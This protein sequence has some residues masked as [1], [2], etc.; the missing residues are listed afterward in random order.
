MV[1]VNSQLSVMTSARAY[2]DADVAVM[3]SAMTLTGD[4][5]TRGVHE[6]RG[7][8]FTESLDGA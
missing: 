3:T 8:I 5:A 7:S 4:P 1:K 2:V 6:A